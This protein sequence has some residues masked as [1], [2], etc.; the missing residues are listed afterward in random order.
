VLYELTTG[1]RCFA[2]KTD[3]DRMLAVV[4]GDYVRPRDLVASFP[5]D[6]EQVI[7][8]ALSIDANHRFASAAA[9]IEALEHVL[10]CR[11]WS[12]G[13]CAI[14]A[15]MAGLF[16]EV[17]MPEVL[18][19]EPTERHEV[20]PIRPRLARGTESDLPYDSQPTQLARGSHPELVLA[21]K[22]P[23]PV[24]EWQGDD[25]L[26]RGRRTLRRPASAPLLVR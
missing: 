18:A 3:F 11:G 1:A 8:C 24:E 5:A 4:R 16:G 7:R 2:G 6:L 13:A 21:A 19:G 25:E 20:G 17:P 23:V 15:T 26:T 22:A 14:Q 10:R 9:L 12:G